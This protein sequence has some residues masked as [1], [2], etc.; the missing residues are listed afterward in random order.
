MLG[1]NKFIIFCPYSI[2]NSIDQLLDLW[3]S[4]LTYMRSIIDLCG[5]HIYKPTNIIVDYKRI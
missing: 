5:V 1:F 4:P 2:I 3:S